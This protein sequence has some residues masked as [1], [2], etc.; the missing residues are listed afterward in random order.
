MTLISDY[1]VYVPDKMFKRLYV[2]S[3]HQ[4]LLSSVARPCEWPPFLKHRLTQ[5]HANIVSIPLTTLWITSSCYMTH[6]SGRQQPA[7]AP[8]IHLATSYSQSG[9]TPDVSWHWHTSNSEFQHV[10]VKSEAVDWTSVLKATPHGSTSSLYL[11]PNTRVGC[12]FSRWQQFETNET[13]SLEK[14][15]QP[16]TWVTSSSVNIPLP[17]PTVKNVATSDPNRLTKK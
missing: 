6:L 10:S 7:T 1:F 5:V 16:K 11:K 13:S 15:R 3:T 8:D 9:C 4:R 17:R 2:F 12:A 14:K